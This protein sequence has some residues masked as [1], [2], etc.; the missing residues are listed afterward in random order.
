MIKAASAMKEFLTFYRK[1][2]I[3]FE[4]ALCRKLKEFSK[5]LRKVYIDYGF[6]AM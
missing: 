6:Q 1:N 4:E 2:E 3:Y 5:E